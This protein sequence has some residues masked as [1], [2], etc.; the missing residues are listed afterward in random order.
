MMV[1]IFFG[2][3]FC[4]P[5]QCDIERNDVLHKSRHVLFLCKSKKMVRL[6]SSCLQL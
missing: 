1:V 4:L 5:S 3:F 2:L 6:F